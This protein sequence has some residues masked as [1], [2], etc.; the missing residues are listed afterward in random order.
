MLCPSEPWDAGSLGL[1]SWV[2]QRTSRH[3]GS[4][5]FWAISKLPFFPVYFLAWPLGRESSGRSETPLCV[6][7]PCQQPE[8][9][10]LW[11]GQRWNICWCRYPDCVLCSAQPS[12]SQLDISQSS[13]QPWLESGPG[14]LGMVRA[15]S[16]LSECP[17]DSPTPRSGR[18]RAVVPSPAMPGAWGWSQSP[19]GRRQ[20]ETGR[21]QR[22]GRV[23]EALT[24]HLSAVGQRK[25]SRGTRIPR[26]LQQ[27]LCKVSP[28]ELSK[29]AQVSKH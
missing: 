17:L 8:S 23:Q 18:N 3:K 7:Q 24:L 14:E 12:W 4:T 13:L 28:W 29:S 9:V 10:C 1:A 25:E 16:G 5:F 27:S 22:A 2:G 19:T 6:G 11:G 15:S 21:N 20:E 26:G